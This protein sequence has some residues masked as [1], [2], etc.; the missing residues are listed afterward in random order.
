MN[1][2]LK[3]KLFFYLARNFDSMDY[4]PIILWKDIKRKSVIEAWRRRA[5]RIVKGA[6]DYPGLYVHI[7][8]CQT[9]CFFCKF[10]VRVGNAPGILNQYLKCLKGEIEEFSKP[11]KG[12]FFKTLYLAG[13]TP[14]ILSAS[15]LDELYCLLEKKYNVSETSQRLIEATPATLSAEKIKV[16]KKHKVNRLTIG[17]QSMDKHLL[18]RINR[19]NQTA[20]MIRDS[21]K[22]ARRAGIDIINV[23]LVAGIPGQSIESFSRDVDLVLGLRPDAVHIFAYEEEDLVIFYKMGERMTG[24][25]RVKRDE[26]MALADVKIRKDGYHS[27]K[28]ESYL[29]SP[30]A[31]NFQLQL[32]YLAN[33]TLLGLGAEALSYIPGYYAYENSKLEQYLRLRSK[34]E[35]PPYLNGYPLNMVETR[36][37]YIINNIRDGLDKAMFRRLYGVDFDKTYQKEIG[38]LRQLG[39]LEEKNVRVRLAVKSDLE[40]RA[41][42]KFF[43]SP[44]VINELKDKATK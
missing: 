37:N 30:Q 20:A 9:K 5:A 17:I 33:G 2:K 43:F 35:A 13:G 3:E 29:L 41:Y 7:P 11:L 16:L 1:L 15:Q 8:Y 10:R 24:P 44:A 23:D 19:N 32:R 21:Y 22:N 4:P 6:V 38:A 12:V 18:A 28:G 42:S 26:M 34:G 31:A 40:F 36:T 25:D 39:R 14:S 27:Y